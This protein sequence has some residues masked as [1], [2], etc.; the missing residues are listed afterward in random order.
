MYS[1]LS[2]G[3]NAEYMGVPPVPTPSHFHTH[4][5]GTWR[6]PM[7]GFFCLFHKTESL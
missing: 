7:V 2:S 6:T 3:I 4:P 1:A 5:M